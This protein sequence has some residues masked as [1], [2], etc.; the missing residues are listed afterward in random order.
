VLACAAPEQTSKAAAAVKTTLT[1][2]TAKT[3]SE[4]QRGGGQRRGAAV[5]RGPD[6]TLSQVR[7]RE[8]KKTYKA[9]I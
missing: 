1:R 7:R 3:F 5:G 6:A 8:P 2:F 4:Q 9:L